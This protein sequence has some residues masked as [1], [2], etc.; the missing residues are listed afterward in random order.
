MRIQ[1]KD[2]SS[3]EIYDI[4]ENGAS[5]GRESARNDIAILDEAISKSH[6]RIFC[7]DAQWFLEDL[8]SS[9]G[10][11]INGKKLTAPF[12]IDRKTTFALSKRSFVV[13]DVHT[14]TEADIQKP[15]FYGPGS[16]ESSHLSQPV[17]IPLSEDAL[18]PLDEN[19][20]SSQED[21]WLRVSVSVLSLIPFAIFRPRQ[22]IQEGINNPRYKGRERVD[23]LFVLLPLTLLIT[24]IHPSFEWLTLLFRDADTVSWSALRVAALVCTSIGMSIFIA[25]LWHP[26]SQRIIQLLGGFSTEESRTNY[27]FSLLILS[28]FISFASGISN[29]LNLLSHP[30]FLIISPLLILTGTIIMS[31]LII[32][33]NR[34]F[35]LNKKFRYAASFVAVLAVLLTTAN[36]A[37]SVQASVNQLFPVPQNARQQPAQNQITISP[38]PAPGSATTVNEVS[39]ATI[40]KQRKQAEQKTSPKKTVETKRSQNQKFA[41]SV[42]TKSK[43]LS[44]FE[45]F[46]EQR[47][48]IESQIKSDPT[49]IRDKK[50]LR[51]YSRIWKKTYELRDKY[52]KKK[53]PRWQRERIFSRQKDAEI[54]DATRKD[55]SALY[56]YMFKN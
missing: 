29:L 46:I 27:L 13:L 24:M 30:L 19:E 16:S 53:G 8:N 1:I 17:P 22:F 38:N 14:T 48:A 44:A 26:T 15:N 55:V 28:A 3:G 51:P 2:L 41:Q 9:N 31:Y 34:H 33:W 10:C 47:N 11:F 40:T 20:H 56:E 5:I 7:R 43:E 36:F 6:A 21:S 42:E 35:E 39:S 52:R 45:Q 54:F 32:A 12:P 18:Q 4:G 23:L 25:F 49:L 37:T 50:V